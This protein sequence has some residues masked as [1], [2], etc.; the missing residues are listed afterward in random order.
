MLWKSPGFTAIALITL[1]LG[2]GANTVMFSLVNALLLRPAHVKE[3][4][5]L[6]GCRS[7]GPLYWFRY[8]DYVNLRDSNPIFSDLM[9]HGWGHESVMLQHGDSTRWASAMFVSAN[10]FSTLGVVP[11][12][13]RDFWPEEERMGAAPVVVLGHR[14]WQRQGGDPNI[15]GTQVSIN[16]I[17]CQVIGVAPEQFTGTALIG[18]DLWLPLG[19]H[20]L[21]TRYALWSGVSNAT[22]ADFASEDWNYPPLLMVGRLKPGLGWSAAEARLPALASRL[23]ETSPDRRV[24]RGSLCLHRLGKLNAYGGS[25]QKVVSA[26]S[27]FL[28]GVS[29]IILL[30]A[31][32]NL[33][34]MYVIQGA[35]RHREMAIR[36]A[37]G[38]GRMR[39]MRQSFIESLLLAL[40][41]GTLG[42]ILA[43]WGVKVLNV[44]LAA[45]WFS[46][47]IGLAVE[48][49]IDARVLV[50]TLGFC[51][52]AAL[53][54]G[55][56]P[57]LRLSRRDIIDDLKES[58][59]SALRPAT[60]ARRIMPR[61]LSVACQVALSVA[62]V[63]AASLL[64]HS[65]WTAAH[66]TPGYS[67]D[68]KLL[69]E[70][71]PR[72]TGYDRAENMQ[73]CERLM[74]RLGTVP[75]VQAVGLSTSK[76]FEDRGKVIRE[77]GTDS[78]GGDGGEGRWIHSGVRPIGGDYFE[79]IGLP[80]L[81]G[82]YFSHV[83][84]ATDAPVVIIDEVQARR[85]RRDGNALGC[86]ISGLGPAPREVIGIVPSLRSSLFETEVSAHVYIP[87]RRDL[88]SFD[89]PVYINVRT[90]GKVPGGE[91]ALL[92]NIREGIHQVDPHVAILS[93]M[94]LSDHH[95]QSRDVRRV[96]LVAGLAMAF[97]ATAL[98]LAALGIYAV[99]GYMVAA[100]TPEIGIRMA[101]GATRGKILRQMLREGAMLTLVGLSAGMLLACGAARVMRHALFGVD[102]FDPA[103]IAMT[104]AL[105]GG[106]SLLASY[107]PARRAARVD[108]MTALRCE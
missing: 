53:L 49:G 83:E 70:V 45:L 33:A 3:P 100:R 37:I 55:V 73:V 99:K 21:V 34:N 5:R 22:P 58:R 84:R 92:Q 38:G 30:I 108:P 76:P 18:P 40:L 80:L 82:R 77:Y 2:I 93:A 72:R 19:A 97:G 74:D 4:D 1:A 31:C 39:L 8:A 52:V 27:L 41:G 64:T 15:V 90:T 28:M 20:G 86:L 12:R 95:R 102:P 91:T 67:F 11:A 9:A 43:F 24:M 14:T 47:E 29:A 65:T 81:R 10:Y 13:G 16:G 7:R 61:G 89:N 32:M 101:L 48:A 104:V 59:G 56:R 23:N 105:L 46:V 50:A 66:M 94:T 68:N 98:F 62:L 75:G 25:D 17:L 42:L 103:S 79:A 35:S 26:G 6:A 87:I 96:R 107:L 51:L 60:R 88:E 78:D 57:A 44:L 36:M 63:M 85:L 54:S 69:I 106:A 71:E